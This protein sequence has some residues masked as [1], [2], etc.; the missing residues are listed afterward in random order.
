MAGVL[1]RDTERRQRRRGN[2]ANVAEEAKAHRLRPT[3]G[4]AK[5]ESLLEPAGGVA[6]PS[7]QVQTSCL[8]NCERIQCCFKP[9]NLWTFVM[10]AIGC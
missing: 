2:L 4:K 10:A 3:A 9:P 8:Q 5:K 6:L 7:T 1:I